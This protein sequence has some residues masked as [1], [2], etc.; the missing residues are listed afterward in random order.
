MPRYKPTSVFYKC[1]AHG[2]ILRIV[3]LCLP[4]CWEKLT[5]GFPAAAK[6]AA[7]RKAYFRVLCFRIEAVS[8]LASSHRFM[9]QENVHSR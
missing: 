7:N 8:N 9:I 1:M 3:V 2:I 5:G 6:D 4:Q